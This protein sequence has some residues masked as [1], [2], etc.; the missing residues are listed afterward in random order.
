RIKLFSLHMQYVIQRML[1]VFMHPVDGADFI[2]Y[3]GFFEFFIAS[4]KCTNC[5]SGIKNRCS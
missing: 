2:T 5:S 1:N 4:I 3:N